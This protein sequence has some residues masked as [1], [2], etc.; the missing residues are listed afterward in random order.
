MTSI[1]NPRK[2][3]QLLSSTLMSAMLATALPVSVQGKGD[4]VMLEEIIVT[5]RKRTEN[6]QDVPVA[7][8]AISASNIER[9]GFESANDISRQVPNMQ[10]STPHNQLQPIFSIRGISMSDYAVNQASPIAVY[11]DEAYLGASFTHGLNFHDIERIEVLRGPQG[12]LFG[13]NSTGGAINLISVSP[14]LSG[15]VTGH[16]TAGIGNYNMHSLNGAIESPLIEDELAA[17]LAFSYKKDD[18]YFDNKLG[19][20]DLAQTNYRAARLSV[21]WQ[22]NEE[23]SA[24]FKYN[25]G[26]SDAR[27]TPPRGEGRISVPGLGDINFMGYQRPSSFDPDEGEIGTVGNNE[28]DLDQ[29]ILTLNYE[30]G[31]FEIVSVSSWLK[32]EYSRVID[33]DGA[34]VNLTEAVGLADTQS[35]TQDLR[36]VSQNEGAFDFI[37]GIYYSVEEIDNRTGFL[38]FEGTNI[39]QLN[40]ETKTFGD[41]LS[42]FGII[43]ARYETE[44]E[45]LALYGQFDFDLSDKMQ[46]SLGVRYTEDEST[47]DYLNVS[48]L[49]FDGTP[50]GSFVPGNITE[51]TLNIDSI[52]L[53][54]GVL[55]PT[56]PG[57]YLNG[58]YTLD[59]APELH[60]EEGEWS[61]KLSLS[62]DITETTMGYL[63][64]SHGYR[65]GSFNGGA[66]YLQST[67]EGVYADPEF[68][69]MVELGVKSDLLDNRLRINAAVFKYDYTDQQ[70]SNV[71]GVAAKIE[72]AG[73]SEISGLEFEALLQATA[74]LT[75]QM[76][77]G[78]LDTEYTEL[79]LANGATPDPVDRIDLS[80]NELISAPEWNYSFAL[81]YERE[82]FI[83]GGTLAIHID[84]NYQDAQWFSAYNDVN[85]YDQIGQED[86]W[87]FGGRVSW[88]SADEAYSVSLWG[89][90]L[91]N[92]EYDSYAINLQ[93]G[94]GLDYFLAGAPRQW[95]VDFGYRF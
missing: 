17:R 7:V 21:N 40:P 49:D 29:A 87:L 61:G 44:K 60:E 27:T 76:N 1:T 43:D 93:G 26:K 28:L 79:D 81:D 14:E 78:W 91:T 2:S 51:G 32:A 83:A 56:D 73:E 77:V 12:T 86:Y 89:K 22:P 33:T 54:P 92:E 39:L 20:D 6:L 63:S 35:F 25:Y 8:S 80:G 38:G 90:N 10:V 67:G 4:T 74:N 62:Y 72:N 84:G 11:V 3:T 58:P 15:P 95:G 30:L 55:S 46:L 16:V 75:L 53:P 9:L 41:L 45:S 23:L 13:K 57:L 94:F 69:D 5:A 34:P 50:I 65:A 71:I 59:S 47:M 68:V 37:L 48:R 42:E 85:G 18:G 66:Y 70:F 31:Q 64:F 82:G 88:R 36:L 19:G 52:F 24:L